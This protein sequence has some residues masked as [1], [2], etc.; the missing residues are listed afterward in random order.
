MGQANMYFHN[1]KMSVNYEMGGEDTTLT[2]LFA[3]FVEMTRI[4]GYQ[5]GSWVNVISDVSDIIDVK[6]DI[7]EWAGDV[8]FDCELQ[9]KN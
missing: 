2:E 4:M 9:K 8:I 3:H 1:D 7:F 5:P 6:Y